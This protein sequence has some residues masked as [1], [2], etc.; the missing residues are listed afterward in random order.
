MKAGGLDRRITVERAVKETDDF[1][2]VRQT[3]VPL[4]SWAAAV[5][6]VS[7]AERMQ[8]GEL[9][10]SVE[11][12]FTIRW[13]LGVTVEDRVLYEGRRYEIVAVKEIGRREGQEISAK[14]RAE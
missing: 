7:D 6:Y 13:G 2:G 4:A 10:A 12:R 1:G 9:S 3:W 11:V 14:A 5:R 8:A